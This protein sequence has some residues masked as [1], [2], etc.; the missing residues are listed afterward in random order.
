VK[1]IWVKK[2]KASEQV[3]LERKNKSL[4]SAEMKE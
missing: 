3:K 2:G 1:N 4:D